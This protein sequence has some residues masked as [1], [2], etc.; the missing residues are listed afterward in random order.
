MEA[1]LDDLD[2]PMEGQVVPITERKRRSSEASSSV[3]SSIVVR[4]II[5]EEVN[6]LFATNLLSPI[7]Q[8]LQ[9]QM[10]LV[11]EQQKETVEAGRGVVQEIQKLRSNNK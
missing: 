11:R 4:T 1:L 8:E 10:Q 5:H 6:A 9:E 7:V 3:V 2:E